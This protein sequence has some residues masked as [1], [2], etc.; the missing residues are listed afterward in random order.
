VYGPIWP[1]KR[2]ALP[3]VC[4]IMQSV[5]CTL[6]ARLRLPILRSATSHLPDVICNMS[7]KETIKCAGTLCM[8]LK[9][10]ALLYR[11]CTQPTFR[12]EAGLE[13]LLRS[14]ASRKRLRK[15][16]PVPEVG[17][18]VPGGYNKYGEPCLPGWGVS[19]FFLN[20]FISNQ[21]YSDSIS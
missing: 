20:S 2:L 13:Y 4:L 8:T 12:A 17:Y 6:T 18:S 9:D 5:I 16:K 15:G 14:P 7:N 1:V 21:N 10:I 11:L 19:N 3:F